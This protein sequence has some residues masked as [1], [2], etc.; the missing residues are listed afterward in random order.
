MLNALLDNPVVTKEL[1]GRMRGTRTYWL[2]FGYLLI[3]SLVLF[4]RT[5][6]GRP[7]TLPAGKSAEARRV[8]RSDATF[9]RPYSI[10]RP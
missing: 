10:R 7:S 9:S 8:L 5:S 6:A 4:S 2:L 3:L 1:R